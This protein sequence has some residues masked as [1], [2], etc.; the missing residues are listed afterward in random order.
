M[1]QLDALIEGKQVDSGGPVLDVVSPATGE[2]VAQVREAGPVQ[3]AVAV[4][5]ARASFADWSTRP[6]GERAEVLDRLAH[7]IERNGDA[8]VDAVSTEMGM[9]FGLARPTQVE[10]VASVLRR[11]AATAR[12]FPWVAQHDGFEVHHLA[13]GVVAAITPWNMPAYQVTTK[14]GPALAAGCTAVLKPSELAPTAAHRFVELAHEA[15]LP[16]GVLNV[17]HGRGPTTGE[18][19][20]GSEGVDVVSFTGSVAAGSRV[21]AVAGAGLR[22]VALELGGKSA[23]VVLDDADLDEVIPRAV[24]A[25]FVNSGQACNAPTRLLVPRAAMA[26]VEVLAASTVV[27][28][29]VGAPDRPDTDLGPLVSHAQHARVTGFLDRALAAGAR[30][31]AG[32]EGVQS[33]YFGPVVLGDVARDSEIAREEVFGPVLVLLPY[34][35]DA[36]AIRLANDTR[37]GLSAELWSPD[38][39]RVATVAA[40]LRSGQVKVN[41]VRTRERPDAPFGGFGAS[42]V[43][44]ELGTWGLHEFLEVKA[45]LA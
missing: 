1:S 18:I 35:D 41:G 43:G 10:L 34:D 4:A 26:R 22:R 36:D 19:L 20:V 32:V 25:A 7:L 15:G 37:Y 30:V 31:V 42:G 28:L 6:V 33:P 14:L 17:V 27:R 39:A 23:T 12:E 13:A 2:I 16:A 45:V 40:G 5:A 21:A 24:R 8:I 9:P 38:P 11:T 29:R 3:V 44:R